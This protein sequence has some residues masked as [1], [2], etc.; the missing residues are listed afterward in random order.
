MLP[1]LHEL[2][3]NVSRKVITLVRLYLIHM[4]PNLQKLGK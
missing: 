4:L 3:T 1:N 2:G